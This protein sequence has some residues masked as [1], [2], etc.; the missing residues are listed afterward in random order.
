M[1]E[2]ERLTSASFALPVGDMRIAPLLADFMAVSRRHHLRFPR[3]L[4]LLVKVVA[5]CEGLAE[6]LDPTFSLTPLLAEFLRS[7]VQLPPHSSG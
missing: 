2:L 3:E 4:G 5:M 6:R 1:A 7:G